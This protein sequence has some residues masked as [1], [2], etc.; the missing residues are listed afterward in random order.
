MVAQ[1]IKIVTIMELCGEAEIW[2]GAQ[3]LKRWCY[4]EGK[5][6]AGARLAVAMAAYMEETGIVEEGGHMADAGG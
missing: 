6:L 5:N 3:V 4:Q 2:P 1:Y